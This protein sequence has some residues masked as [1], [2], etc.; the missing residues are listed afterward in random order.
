MRP[1]PGVRDHYFLGRLELAKG[2]NYVPLV[3]R[4]ESR[5]EL[6]ARLSEEQG[7]RSSCLADSPR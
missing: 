4:S 7:A 1:N 5:Q 3:A 2:L 6:A